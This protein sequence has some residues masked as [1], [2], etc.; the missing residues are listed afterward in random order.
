MTPEGKIKELVKTY[1]KSLGTDCWFFMPV[2]NG[3]GVHGIPDI[4]GCYKGRSFA[5]ETKK[6]GGK[7]TALQVMQITKIQEAGGFAI[8]VDGPEALE[9]FKRWANSVWVNTSFPK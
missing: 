2:S 1:L 6:P 3:L 4:I 9:Q 5:I 8:V 7:P